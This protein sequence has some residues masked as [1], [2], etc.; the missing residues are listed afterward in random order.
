MNPLLGAFD[1]YGGLTRVYSLL[2]GSPVIDQGSPSVCPASD[3]VGLNRPQDG[4]GDG[5]LVCDMGATEYLA[6]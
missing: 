1:T 5:S 2:V 3:P 4:D 6:H